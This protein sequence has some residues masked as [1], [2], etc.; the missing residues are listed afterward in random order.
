VELLDVILGQWNIG[1]GIED[2]L[3]RFR[4]AGNLLFISR[5]EGTQIKIRQKQ[6]HLNVSQCRAFNSRGCADGFHS[7]YALEGCKAVGRKIPERFPR[8][9]EFIDLA[10]QSE[11]VRRERRVLEG[12]DGGATHTRKYT[13]KYPKI[14]RVS[15]GMYSGIRFRRPAGW[16]LDAMFRAP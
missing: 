8:A 14:Y 3:G 13:L 12:I 2:H 16:A 6:V 5:L 7:C 1:P 11:K 10:D 15:A 9:L 4:V